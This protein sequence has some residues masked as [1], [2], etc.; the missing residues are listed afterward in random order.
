[1]GA[2]STTRAQWLVRASFPGTWV[3]FGSGG[4][5]PFTLRLLARKLAS[6]T[7]RFALFPRGFLR[8]FFVKSSTLHL[9]EDA[10]PLHFLLQY[11]ECLIDIVVADEYLQKTNPFECDRFA[12]LRLPQVTGTQELNNRRIVSFL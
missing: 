7:D 9:A 1:L 6:S 8:R 2:P 3:F 10:F 12:L 5:Q 4:D 11:S